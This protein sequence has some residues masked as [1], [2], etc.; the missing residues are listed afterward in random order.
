M[1]QLYKYC[2]E[3]AFRRTYLI[4][5]TCWDVDKG[6]KNKSSKIQIK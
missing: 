1:Q 3:N 6:T 5:Y 2:V 4:A